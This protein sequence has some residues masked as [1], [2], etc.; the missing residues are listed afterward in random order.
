MKRVV[1]YCM[2]FTLATSSLEG[3]FDLSP[4]L[5][6]SEMFQQTFNE[7]FFWKCIAVLG[8]SLWIA[9]KT[10]PLV[11]RWFVKQRKDPLQRK[12]GKFLRGQRKI[13]KDFVA[14]SDQC[15]E[16]RQDLTAMHKKMF[17]N[18]EVALED[19]KEELA[20]Q[21]SSLKAVKRRFKDVVEEVEVLKGTVDIY[22]KD[23]LDVLRSVT[24]IKEKEG[25]ILSKLMSHDAEDDEERNKGLINEFNELS[26]LWSNEFNTLR[27]IV[28][29]C[30]QVM[31]PFHYFTS[32]IDGYNRDLRAIENDIV[33][34]K[35]NFAPLPQLLQQFI[36]ED[37]GS[38]NEESTG[39][40]LLVEILHSPRGSYDMVGRDEGHPMLGEGKNDI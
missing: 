5:F 28:L 35:I 27:N 6:S 21:K 31:K 22:S 23:C 38:D 18:I 20:L 19:S 8:V 40:Q 36:Q 29:Y 26:V 14:L 34:L 33:Q 30:E 16:L 37:F 2:V 24:R 3:K 32:V 39:D 7:S 12:Y 17:N 10:F 1:L 9:D 25:S 15:V 11:K 13:K 4:S